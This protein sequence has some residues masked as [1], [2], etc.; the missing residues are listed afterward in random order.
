MTR[1][2]STV[3]ARHVPPAL[4]GLDLVDA[5][6]FT[7]GLD[8]IVREMGTV[9]V[10]TTGS[11][12]IAESFDFSTFIADAEGEIIAFGGYTTT[13]FGPARQSTR[14]LIDTIP[15]AEIEPG[16]A[17]ICNDPY[18][19]GNAHA[20]DMGIVRPVFAPTGE[21][22]AW[23]WAEAHMEDAGGMSPGGMATDARE[24][25]AEGLRLPGIKIVSRGR[26]LDD[27]A[28]LLRA[29]L[30]VADEVI[31]E[32]RCFI[33]ACNTCDARLQDLLGTLGLQEFKRRCEVSKYLTE[34][35]TRA[36]IS[37][38]PPGAV[39]DDEYVEHGG[40]LHRVHCKLA[41][42]GE[43]M[44]ID[45]TGS[46]PQT[47][48]FVNCVFAACCAQAL[49]PVVTMLIPDLPINEGIL[50]AVDVVAEEGTIVNPLMPAPCSAG[51]IEVGTRVIK[52]V[53]RLLASLQ[54]RSELPEVRE[55]AMAPWH[56]CF[57]GGVF[58]AGPRGEPP[59]PF[60]DMAA[61]SG[62]GGA[63]ESRDGL[64][65]A[66]ALPSGRVSLPDVE[67]SERHAPLLYLWRR[68][69]QGAGGVGRTRGGHAIDLAWTPW[70]TAGG[71]ESAFSGCREVP[72]AGVF[73]G[74]PGSGSHYE[75][76]LGAD[77]AN[78]LAQGRIPRSLAEL[79][80]HVEEPEAKSFS[81]A[82]S[83]GDVLRLRVGGGGGFGDPLE[84]D[85]AAVLKDVAER[86]LTRAAAAAGYG[87][88]ID[89][90]G[91]LDLVATDRRRAE[92]RAERR[93]WP[94]CGP[95]VRPAGARCRVSPAAERLAEIGAW[96][97]PRPG[98]WLVEYADAGSADL[99]RVD[100]VVGAPPAVVGTATAAGP[101]A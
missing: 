75:H 30:R 28:R 92:I 39:E 57:P 4:D 101:R 13:H 88:V 11:L 42:E 97:R 53:T 55:R 94:A 80:G 18:T 69:N 10:R 62:G 82:M 29:N 48:S 34:R 86:T 33:A 44:T 77:V 96:S 14:Y 37:S 43:S 73:G 65:F 76:V 26:F 40:T 67:M 6:I 95:D 100:V 64:D 35:A 19:T 32:L 49:T 99:L 8:D 27:V 12:A 59:A 93:S 78:Q 31:N 85:P 51:H 87:V 72:P 23:C 21:L 36:R 46:D 61:N 79:A 70:K 47:E 84:R 41:V 98:I 83:E 1:L 81:L 7:R 9:M 50:R 15:S 45:L 17:F 54:A 3:P 68:V 58:F 22:A 24:C 60:L 2:S 5:E 74:Y 16:D 91:D 25:Y 71:V 89:E 66:G 90:R 56:D 20:P 63:L 52:V 38:L